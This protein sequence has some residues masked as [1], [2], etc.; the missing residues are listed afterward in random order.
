MSADGNGNVSA[1]GYA[2]G[3]NYVHYDE[4]P[5]L[6]HRGEAVLTAAEARVWRNGQMTPAMAGG[7]TINQYIQSVPQTP[8]ELAAA[9][10]AYFEQ[11]RWTL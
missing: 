2:T 11:S 7:I 5:A 9:T 3:L 1:K 6:L 4:F 8:V 10:E